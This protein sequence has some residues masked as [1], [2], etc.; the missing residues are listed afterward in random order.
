MSI[1]ENKKA[2]FEKTKTLLEYLHNRYDVSIP[3]LEKFDLDHLPIKLKY[4]LFCGEHNVFLKDVELMD[5]YEWWVDRSVW[6]NIHLSRPYPRRKKRNGEMIYTGAVF[7]IR[8]K[9]E[10]DEKNVENELN[11]LLDANEKR[12]GWMY[13]KFRNRVHVISITISNHELIDFNPL[14]HNFLKLINMAYKSYLKFCSF[15]HL[16]DKE[17]DFESIEKLPE[18]IKP[19]EKEAFRKVRLQHGKFK[20]N[21]KEYYNKNGGIKCK[22][23]GLSFEDVLI[24]SHIKP[25]SECKDSEWERIDPY[26]G[27]LL[28]PTHDA[29]FDKN[30]I[31]FNDDGSIRISRKIC[32]D[33]FCK[34][35]I[36]KDLRIELHEKNKTYLKWHRG[37]F[38]ELEENRKDS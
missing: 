24:A 36:K 30:L 2:L 31:T 1:E 7:E 14:S 4:G 26:N 11:K 25:W 9:A 29:L 38:E 8:I 3:T 13:Y 21:L 19:T 22:L 6:I 12:Y 33:D 37:K 20:D 23:C 35:N 17:N 28:C 10:F 32:E 16:L 27:F 5:N 15:H 18:Q 34:L